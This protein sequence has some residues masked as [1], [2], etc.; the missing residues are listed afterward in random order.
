MQD[1][2]QAQATTETMASGRLTTYRSG[3]PWESGMLT[4][5]LCLK[6]AI[7]EH[8]GHQVIRWVGQSHV[9]EVVPIHS[10]IGEGKGTEGERNN[11]WLK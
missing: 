11:T 3:A 7:N 5:A 10:G 2:H 9:M 6:H 4:Y 8:E 1:A